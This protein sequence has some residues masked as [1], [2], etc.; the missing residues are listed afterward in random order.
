MV[1][2]RTSSSTAK[3]VKVV[4]SKPVSP[5]QISAQNPIIYRRYSIST[6]RLTWLITHNLNTTKFNAIC[7][8]EENN[9]FSAR[10]KT[11][12]TDSFAIDLTE[13]IRGTVDVIFDTATTQSIIIE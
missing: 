1:T 12:D 3:A 6:P 11:I 10:I 9:V 4:A 13:A 8:D 2:A 7:R 5:S